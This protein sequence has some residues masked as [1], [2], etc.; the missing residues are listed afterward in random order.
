MK[1]EFIVCRPGEGE[2]DEIQKI[3]LL[4]LRLELKQMKKQKKVTE[5]KQSEKIA[6]KEGKVRN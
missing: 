3:K 5:E 4:P 2:S 1:P 6:T